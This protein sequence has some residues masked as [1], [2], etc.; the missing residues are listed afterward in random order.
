MVKNCKNCLENPPKRAFQY[1]KDMNSNS[2]ALSFTRVAKPKACWRGT[3]TLNSRQSK[4]HFMPT[5]WPVFIMI[6][7]LHWDIE[8]IWNFSR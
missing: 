8:D 6:H 4:A 2:L 7:L 1:K 5:L 3:K